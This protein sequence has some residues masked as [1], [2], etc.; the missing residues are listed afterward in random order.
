[1]PL[2]FDPASVRVIFAH[3]I[4]GMAVTG[5][6]QPVAVNRPPLDFDKDMGH[7]GIEGYLRKN[8]I[9]IDYGRE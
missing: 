3:M 2:D 7:A 8:A 5:I 1:M 9:W 4:R 6:G